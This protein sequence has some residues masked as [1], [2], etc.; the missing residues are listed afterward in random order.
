MTDEQ[1]HALLDQTER[2]Q[3]ELTALVIVLKEAVEHLYNTLAQVKGVATVLRDDGGYANQ[4]EPSEALHPPFY[5]PT[6]LPQNTD[7][8]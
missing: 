1:R 5:L 2:I 3:A 6:R 8:G 7:N 4:R